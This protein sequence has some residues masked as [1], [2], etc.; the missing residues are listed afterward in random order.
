MNV[1][2]LNIK[3]SAIKKKKSKVQVHVN[4]GWERGEKQK[5]DG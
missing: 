1:L 3:C 4:G 2:L 5:Q